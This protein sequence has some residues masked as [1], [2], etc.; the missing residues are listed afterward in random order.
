MCQPPPRQNFPVASKEAGPRSARP[1]RRERD[2]DERRDTTTG[3]DELDNFQIRLPSSLSLRNCSSICSVNKPQVPLCL[4]APSISS[5]SADKVGHFKVSVP[6]TG[7]G[8]QAAIALVHLAQRRERSG[9]HRLA[10]TSSLQP[11]GSRALVLD[12]TKEFQD[13]LLHKSVGNLS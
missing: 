7:N 6:V 4:I 9:G 2:G 12:G 3:G 1:R 11:S 10:D 13:R 5:C 8:A